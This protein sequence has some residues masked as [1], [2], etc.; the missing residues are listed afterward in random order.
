MRPDQATG[1]ATVGTGFGAEAGRQGGNGDGQ[2]IGSQRLAGEQVGER[3]FGGGDEEQLAVANAGLE[4]VLLKLRQLSSARHGLATDERWH[5][6]LDVAV[7][8]GVQGRK[9]LAIARCN[10]APAPLTTAKRGPESLVAAAK[11]KMWSR[12]P[13]ST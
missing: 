12:S 10:T 11:S 6:V 4:Q 9:K 5:G 2:S 8:G 7:A 1:I 3:D 13:I